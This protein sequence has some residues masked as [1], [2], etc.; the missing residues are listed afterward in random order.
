MYEIRFFK[1][2]I[3]LLSSL[4]LVIL[5]VYLYGQLSFLGERYDLKKQLKADIEQEQ[6]MSKK[7]KKEK[8]T[9]EKMPEL[10]KSNE[11]KGFTTSDKIASELAIIEKK[12]EIAN[13]NVAN[14][15]LEEEDYFRDETLSNEVIRRK[16]VTMNVTANSDKEL[17]TLVKELEN[18]SKRVSKIK[19]I[20]YKASPGINEATSATVVFY[21]YYVDMEEQGGNEWS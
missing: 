11:I 17:E 3:I 8:K 15:M 19:S 9:L 18:N 2:H 1:K 10:V 4:V 14:I 5:A 13:V 16:V 7:L 21:M 20:D 12:V 6:L